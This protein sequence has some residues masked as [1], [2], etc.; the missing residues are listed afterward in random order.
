MAESD[1]VCVLVVVVVVVLVL[2]CV[3][4]GGG[5][6]TTVTLAR[7]LSAC[8]RGGR[9]LWASIFKVHVRVRH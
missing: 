1:V 7:P 5:I 4:V 8:R 9:R 3:C 6:C 2:W